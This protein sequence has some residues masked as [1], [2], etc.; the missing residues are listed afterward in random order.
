MNIQISNGL[1]LV[2][3]KILALWNDIILVEGWNSITPYVVSHVY[4][5]KG[6]YFLENGK[7]Y[8][9]KDDAVEE[10]KEKAKWSGM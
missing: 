5:N 4:E 8:T 2:D 1:G 9:N 7:Y 3:L 6:N 10:W